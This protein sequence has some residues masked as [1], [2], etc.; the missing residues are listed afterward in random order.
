MTINGKA[1]K[2]I[3]CYSARRA[4]EPGKRTPKTDWRATV[5]FADGSTWN[6]GGHSSK[7]AAQ[8]YAERYAR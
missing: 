8:A 3:E 5:Q 6:D 2:K 1:V 4:F 7:K